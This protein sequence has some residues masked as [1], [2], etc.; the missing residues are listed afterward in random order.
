[1]VSLLLKFVTKVEIICQIVYLCRKITEN[2]IQK[3]I[4]HRGIVLN[5][6]A[7]SKTGYG[8]LDYYG[9]SNS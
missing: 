6:V 8:R 2:E 5:D 1:M 3:S 9:G 4:L 7:T